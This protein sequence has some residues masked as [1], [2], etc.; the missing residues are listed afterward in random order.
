VFESRLL[1][2]LS[3]SV[4]IV[5]VLSVS[6]FGFTTTL[7]QNDKLLVTDNQFV[8][9]P[10][11]DRLLIFNAQSDNIKT[12]DLTALGLNNPIL[13]VVDNGGARAV[14]SD[15]LTVTV[16]DLSEGSVLSTLTLAEPLRQLLTSS[17]WGVVVAQSLWI[18]DLSSG[19]KVSQ[20]PAQTFGPG[21]GRIPVGRVLITPEETFVFQVGAQRLFLFDRSKPN[22]PSQAELP[23]AI[24]DLTTLSGRVVARTE[25]ELFI[26]DSISGEI[27]NQFSL[28]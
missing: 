11:V 22:Q 27:L 21:T 16:V 4:L 3:I 18:I 9:V 20:F 12:L 5:F 19:K 7:A 13:D 26:I 15:G 17:R 14:V 23:G 8:L 10:L 28:P 6:L 25:K 2:R 24:V 1:P